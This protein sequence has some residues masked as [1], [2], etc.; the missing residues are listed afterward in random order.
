[1]PF[2]LAAFA[3]LYCFPDDTR[4]WFAWN[5]QPTIMGAGYIF[6]QDHV[7][8]WISIGLYVVTP[9]LVPLAWIV[10]RATDPRTAEPGERPLSRHVRPALPGVTALM[11]RPRRPMELPAGP[12]PSGVARSSQG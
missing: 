2:L 3:L 11:M 7:A 5:V 6:D 1:V 12:V 10:N 8:F 4:H 9:V